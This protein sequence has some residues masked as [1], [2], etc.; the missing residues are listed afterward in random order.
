M[1]RFTGRLMAVMTAAAALCVPALAQERQAEG[2]IDAKAQEA[3]KQMLASYKNISALH[4]V[5]TLKGN[6]PDY[7][8][9]GLPEKVEVKIQRPNKVSIVFSQ[10]EGAKTVTYRIVSDG[11]N[12]WRWQSDTNVYSK[13]KAPKLLSEMPQVGNP[14]PEMEAILFGRNPFEGM[15]GPNGTMTLNKT[16]KRGEVE[17]DVME[18]SVSE[19]GAGMSFSLSMLLGQ[20]DRL[21]RSIRLAG[22][23]KD[24]QGK[25]TSFNFELSYDLVNAK[26]AFTAA[27]F[28]FTPPAGSK[29]AGNRST[30]SSPPKGR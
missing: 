27:D 7:M 30:P 29:P 3:V 16:E 13:E 28:Q 20:K 4:E 23:G 24:P 26:P 6:L 15:P 22:K 2:K 21:I 12:L 18:A 5:V 11:T 14:T 9:S 10:K 8:S 1:F 17:Y 19:E 25:D